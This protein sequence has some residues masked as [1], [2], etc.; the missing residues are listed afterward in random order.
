[1]LLYVLANKLQDELF[2]CQEFFLFCKR[3][4]LSF[5]IL[6]TMDQALKNHILVMSRPHSD[7]NHRPSDAVGEISFGISRLAAI[8][9]QIGNQKMPGFSIPDFAV[10]DGVI[11]F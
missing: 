2:I 4:E 10:G 7:R 9:F 6:Q 5:S 3:T 8:D 11:A 1:M